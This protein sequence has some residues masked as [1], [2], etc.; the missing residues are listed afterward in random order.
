[1]LMVFLAPNPNL[2]LA[3]CC[4]VDVVKG[5]LGCFFFERFVIEVAIKSPFDRSTISLACC[6]FFSFG[7]LP[8]TL[9]KVASKLCVPFFRLA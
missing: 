4:I 6:S 3:S 5:S 7:F 9:D 1:M 8:S 2:V